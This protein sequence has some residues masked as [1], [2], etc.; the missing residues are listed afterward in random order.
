K[1]E[2]G[3]TF[4]ELLRQVR[5]TS[6]GA[7]AHQDL[8]FEKLVEALRPERETGH[9]PFFQVMFDYHRAPL[10]LSVLPGESQSRVK[11]DLKTAKFDL[12]LNIK[13]SHQRFAA[14]L[15]YDAD[16]FDRASMIQLLEQYRA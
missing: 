15:E 4:R 3:M 9:N 11:I 13:D 8:P 1:L 16:R 12:M 10:D 5:E 14:V 6:L 7:Y 2:P